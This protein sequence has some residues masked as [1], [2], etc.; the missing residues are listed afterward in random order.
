MQ[1]LST[2]LVFIVWCSPGI[3]AESP[4]AQLL[5]AETLHKKKQYAESL[6]LAD[7]LLSVP[8]VAAGA[9]KLS[10]ANLALLGRGPEAELRFLKAVEL[11]PKDA[12]ALYYLGFARFRTFKYAEAVAPLRK[13]IELN[14]TH[15]ESYYT[16]AVALEWCQDPSGAEKVYRRLIPL[17]ANTPGEAG[18]PQL[19]LGRLLVTHGR[20]REAIEPLENAVRLLPKSAEALKYLGRAYRQVDRNDDALR[21]FKAAVSLTPADSEVRYLLMRTYRALGQDEQANAEAKAVESM[22]VT[23]ETRK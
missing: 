20:Y 7:R 13:A 17:T 6:A 1:W 15:A 23:N 2:S 21:V 16:L 9:H 18:R 8:E 14:P 10:G 11:A 3:S 4:Q 12:M 19:F 22:T 5:H